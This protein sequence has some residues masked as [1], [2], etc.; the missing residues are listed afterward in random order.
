MCEQSGVWRIAEGT[1][2]QEVESKRVNNLEFGGSEK[3]IQ[4]K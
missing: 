1:T 3:E 2:G 4:G